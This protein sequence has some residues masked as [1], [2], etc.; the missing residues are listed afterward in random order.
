[1]VIGYG[2]AGAVCAITAFDTGANVLVL[3]KT[4]SLAS[5]GVTPSTPANLN[6]EISGGGG[7][8][9]M[10]GG[11]IACPSD[12]IDAANFLYAAS[13]GTT[14]MDVCLAWG[15]VA[16]SNPAW[17]TKMGIQYTL[18]TTSAAT[19]GFANLPGAASYL[20]AAAAGSG[21]GLFYGLDQNVQSRKIPVLFNTPAT[22]LIQ[23]PTTG[24]ILGVRAL[25][26]NSE[27]L[28]IRANRAVILACGGYEYDETMKANYLRSYPTNFYGWQ[29]N[30]GDGIKMAQKVGA[31]LWHMNTQAGSFNAW[32]PG[33]GPMG[34]TISAKGNGWI[35]V[36]TSGQRF[37]NEPTASGDDWDMALSNVNINNPQYDRI[38]TFLV[39][40]ET[41]RKA[42]ALG[43]TTI[44]TTSVPVQLG[45]SPY[46]WS[47]DNS[48]EIALGW[49]IKGATSPADLANAINSATIASVPAGAAPNTLASK[50]VFNI[51]PTT[52]TNTINTYNGYC[53]TGVDLDFGRAKS[54]LTALATPPY[55]AIPVWPGGPNTLG[56]PIHNAKGQVCDPDNNPIPRLYAAG[57]CGSIWGFLYPGRGNNSENI[58][59]GQI[60]GHNAA[61]E[62]PWTD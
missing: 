16:V 47:A 59:F 38:P 32:F 54:T 37:W 62:V 18:S 14:P 35:Y 15:S 42:G 23:D 22:D 2:G 48:A 49:I 46:L 20:Y 25:A 9:H 39:F 43:N 58:A 21:A 28:N 55:Y 26:N 19:G 17:L 29:Y 27:I 56:G 6:F 51:N 33:H 50:M 57:E 52:L 11:N 13:W 34:F 41:C 61:T 31:G 4:P 7:N 8:T 30:T 44:S 3:E 36:N 1:V 40:D 5:L 60:S 10:S 53:A 12:P 45:G 24:E